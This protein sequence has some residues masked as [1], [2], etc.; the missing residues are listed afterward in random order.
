MSVRGATATTRRVGKP[1][2]ASCATR[3]NVILTTRVTD[4]GLCSA[5]SSATMGKSV[6]IHGQDLPGKHAQFFCR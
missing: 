4:N 6:A 3:V 1:T 5:T 2:G